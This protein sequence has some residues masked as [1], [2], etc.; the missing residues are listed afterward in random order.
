MNKTELLTKLEETIPTLKGKLHIERVLYKKVAN[1]A[2]MS[3]L[4]DVLVT[5]VDYLLLERTLAGLF[6]K[7]SVSLRIASP[8]LGED[9]LA[10]I[11]QYKFVLTD[12]LRRQSPALSAWIDD[13][14][15]SM[16]NGRI[17]LTCPDHIAM[18]FFKTHHLDKKVSQAIYDIFRVT[19]P[20]ALTIC[21]ERDEWVKKMR[22]ERGFTFPVKQAAPQMADDDDAPPWDD[23]AM[24]SQAA[25]MFGNG[26]ANGSSAPALAYGNPAKKSAAK[27]KQKEVKGAVLKGRAIADRPVD[28]GELAED[29]GIVVIEGIITGVNDPK[30]LKGGETVLVTFAVYDDTSTIYCKGFYQYRM[31]RGGMGETPTPPSEEEKKRVADQ[32]NQIK[33]G[34]RVRLRGECRMD[35][36]M[37]ELS[38]GV[39]DMQEMPQRERKDLGKEKRIEL[40]MHTNM[41]TMD[42]TAEAGALIAQAAKW[43][44]S[45]VAITDHGCSQAFPA[46]FFAAKKNNIKLIPGVEG[47]LV[48]LIPIVKEADDRLLSSPIVVFDFETTGLSH[49]TDRIIEVGA[50]KLVDGQ[51]TDELSILCDPGVPLR[52][53]ITELTGITDLMLRGKES[54]AS[55]VSKLLEFIGDC[56]VCAHNAPFDIG[57]LNAECSR[58][59]TS[60]SA[61]V[62]DTLTFSR[63]LYPKQ[64]SHTLKSVCRVH[65]VSLKNAHRAVHDASA[66][67]QCLAKMYDEVEKMGAHTL[68]GIDGV[69]SGE[70]MSASN[71]I[72]LLC[73]TQK[74]MQN[75]NHLIS[76]SNLHYFY[77]H[78]NMPRHLIKQYREGLIIGSACEAGELFQAI[79]NNRPDSELEK[80]ASFY[81]YLE[82]QPAGNNEFMI[83]NGTARDMDDLRAYNRR[84][85]DLGERMGIPVVATGDVHFQNPEDAIYRTILQA[86]L[87]YDDCDQQPPLYFKTTDEMLMEFSYLGKDKAYEVVIDAPRKIAEQVEDLRLFPK[88]PKDEDTFQPLWEEAAHDIE[89]CSWGQAKALYGD[90]LP[91][92]VEARLNKELGSIIGYGFATLYSIAQKLVQKSLDDGY[93]VGSRGSVGSSFVATMTGITEVNPLPPH[94]RCDTCHKLFW[95]PPELGTTGVDL[96]D[97]D[98]DICGSKLVKDGFDIPFE[99]FL[100]FKGDKVPDIDLNFSGEY[101]P[102]AHKY[103]EE[104]F[105]E[106]YVFR[107]GTISGLADKTAYGFAAKYLEERGIKAGRAHKERLA[108]GCVGVKRTTGQ[109]PGGIV[110]LPKEYD[111]CQFTAVQ[112]PADAID[113]DTITTHFDFNS[114]H[115]IL[116]K[117][118]C[119]G[120]DDPTMMHRLEE[121]T[122]INYQNIPL[123]D[124]QVMSLF[125]SPDA[126]GVTT[127]QIMC[128]TGTLGVPEFGTKFVQGM[129][130]DTKP[131]T[132]EELIRISGLSHGTDVWLGNAKDLIDNGIAVLKNCI[133]TRDDIMN[134]LI[135]KGVD[136]KMSFDTME[137]VR[138]GRGLTPAMEAAMNEQNV[139]EWFIDSCKKIKYMFPKGHAVA[140]V[141][142]SLRVAWYKVYHPVAYYAAYFTIRGDGFDAAKMLLSNETLR[143]RLNDFE[144]REE[145]LSVREKQEENAFHMV[146]EMQERGIQMLPVDLYKSHLNR[147]LPEDGNLRCPFTSI[148]SFGESAAQGIIDTRDESKPYLSVEDLRMRARVGASATEMLRLQGALEG[149]PETSQVDLFSLF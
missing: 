145:K 138:K 18:N 92:I 144:L 124:K 71:H 53:K 46:A 26:A 32:V 130:M 50:V 102:R 49:A 45:A 65:G 146:L 129:L 48:D 12:F 113:G 9:F 99:V 17:L 127:Q 107:A 72:I 143:D 122:G 81:D 5:E 63:R 14:G 28:I 4:S 87:G 33:N 89:S 118:D 55:G 110:V 88:H 74:G 121:L 38:I 82:I 133:C 141:T 44:H 30:E 23:A 108:A 134:Y 80:I 22:A 60:F 136:S 109:H 77:R 139:P 137:F 149:L 131:T 40:H 36:F 79:V 120:H 73:K 27:P 11:N 42:A 83:R 20:I 115:D 6:P 94:Y 34:M 67:A 96:P 132:M 90:P 21:G 104:L 57:M 100:G 68:A 1:K 2:Y 25:A 140:Y 54:P 29:S 114:M 31:R 97:K 8:G 43:G 147:F 64:K 58:M 15:W 61:P 39:R 106:G 91:E 135:T 47:Y 84:I 13:T 75:L 19:V 70:S 51:I 112:H 66:T 59:G 56:A 105:G 24:E 35:N 76:D 125:T 95:T 93:L 101:Q 119:L 52:P 7:L 41:S 116:V 16:E 10:N 128:D 3:F 148:S 117:L 37:G 126:L 62:L 142:M 123:D 85:V 69:V 111:I 103:V 86:G 98:C 78:P